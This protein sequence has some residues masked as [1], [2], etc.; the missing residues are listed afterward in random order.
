MAGNSGQGATSIKKGTSQDSLIPNVGFTNIEFMHTPTIADTSINLQSLSAPATAVTNGYVAPS[1]SALAAVDLLKFKENLVLRTSTG[2][3]TPFIDYKVTGPQTITYLAPMLPVAGTEIITGT[4]QSVPKTGVTVV[5][6]S[7]L[8]AS[9]TLLA[10]NTD[11]AIGTYEVGKYI[12]EDHGSVMVFI[13]GLLIQRNNNNTTS[14]LKITGDYQEITNIIKMNA[15]TGGN[16]EFAVFSVGSL[17]NRPQASMDAVFEQLQGQIDAM[18]PD[19]AVLAAV[20]ETNYQTAPNNVDLKA[21]SQRILDIEANNWVRTTASTSAASIANMDTF[22]IANY[23][24]AKYFV[25]ITDT[26]ATTYHSTELHVLHDGTSA[27]ITEYGTLWDTASLGSFTADISAGDVRLR[28]TP[29]SANATD[30]EIA[31]LTS[32]V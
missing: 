8:V 17:V 9:G 27:Y 16:R 28:F 29:L 3:L 18:V 25:S 19:L 1:V 11:I 32:D 13:D 21:F 5:D 26:V 23:R 2:I 30:Y 20:P 6:A 24:A 15:S 14:A 22:P 31:R 10:G 12:T 4:I 7:P